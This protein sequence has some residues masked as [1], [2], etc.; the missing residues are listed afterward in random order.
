MFITL[1][2]ST[3]VIREIQCTVKPAHMVTSIK[4]SPVL[5]GHFFLCPVIEICL[6]NLSGHKGPSARLFEIST[7]LMFLSMSNINVNQPSCNPL[8]LA[9]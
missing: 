1:R 5:K 7:R 2:K 4:Q 9:L 6:A 3:S 8:Q